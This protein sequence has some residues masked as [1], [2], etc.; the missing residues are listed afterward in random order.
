MARGCG[1]L[2]GARTTLRDDLDA[3]LSIFSEKEAWYQEEGER[4]R[5]DVS[6]LGYELRKVESRKKQLRQDL[7]AVGC[8]L[9]GVGQKLGHLQA[10]FQALS[11][12]LAAHLLW[13]QEAVGSSQ[14]ERGDMADANSRDLREA[15]LELGSGLCVEDNLASLK[16]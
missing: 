9:G 10:R 2:A 11:Q 4:A 16:L 7:R 14:P 8:G 12:D 3:L 1:A 13:V 6:R 5:S 15:F